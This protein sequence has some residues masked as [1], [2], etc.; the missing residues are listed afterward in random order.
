MSAIFAKIRLHTKTKPQKSLTYY[1]GRKLLYTVAIIA[2]ILSPFSGAAR[3]RAASVYDNVVHTTN[4]LMVGSGAE[5]TNSPYDAT[6]VIGS[7]ITNKCSKTLVDSLSGAVNNGGKWA[8]TNSMY[9][10]GGVFYDIVFVYWS[11]DTNAEVTFDTD[12]VTVP[13]TGLL[14][15][16]YAGPSTGFICLGNTYA[17]NP[18]Q[19]LATAS[20]PWCDIDPNCAVSYLPYVST[21]DVT[22]P[23]GYA[24]ELLPSDPSDTDGDG[25]TA[26][27]E[28][29]LSTDDAKADSDGDGL[30]DYIESFW[31]DTRYSTFCSTAL[32]PYVCALPDPH[33]KDLYVEIDWLDDGVSNYQPTSTQLSLVAAKFG[34]IGI[35]FHADTGEYGGGN[36]INSSEAPTN[37]P[38]DFYSHKYGSIS[39]S[40]NF[41]AVNRYK[42]W[43]YMI[44]GYNYSVGGGGTTSSGLTENGGDDTFL[45]YGS[46]YD[47]PTEFGY[48]DF[49]DAIAGTIVHEL[50]HGI[51]LSDSS[52]TGQDSS[53]LFSGVDAYA[54]SNYHSP[55][56]YTYQMTNQYSYSDGTH[57]TGDHDDISAIMLGIND[58]LNDDD[59]AYGG[60]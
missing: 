11:S 10:T 29:L 18:P 41:D 19:V 47:H 17:Y 9:P 46:I 39:E 20:T 55:M 30:S 8:V 34:G 16:I 58:F 45:S 32:T 3:V 12:S 5:P 42:I 14:Y 15:L 52:Y 27:Q 49:D 40:A 57:G 25:L 43:R 38:T 51:C 56:N 13:V 53:C 44:S 21:Y 37:I 36:A 33:T 54:S 22:Y 7:A 23:T 4:T 26:D 60:L 24:G 50:G 1:L 35:K 6:D 48:S 28:K 31:Y 2:L 59:S